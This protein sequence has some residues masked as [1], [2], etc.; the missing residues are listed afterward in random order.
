MNATQLRDRLLTVQFA[1]RRTFG[2]TGLS[3]A[4]LLVVAASIMLAIPAI[5][6]STRD[7]H[8]KAV[9]ARA[10]TAEAA[11]HEARVVSDAQLLDSL[12]ERFPRFAQSSD[13]VAAILAQ[14]R[15]ANLTLGSAQYQVGGDRTSA[16]TTY[17]VL[18]PVKDRYVAIRRFV[19]LVLNTLPNAA[20]QE[21]HVERPAVSGDVLEARIRFDLIYKGSRS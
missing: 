5:E 4:I 21:I 17:Q 19:A 1:L 10:A 6:A 8:R 3:G 13:D 7:L 15:A 9:L 2:W 12:P 14:A 20:L 18:L 16:Y 11:A